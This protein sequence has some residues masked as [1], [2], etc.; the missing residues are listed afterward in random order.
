MSATA[1]YGATGAI[2]PKAAGY[3]IVKSPRMSPELM[4]MWEQ[5]RGGA[6]PGVQA[7]LGQ[8]SQLAGGGNEELWRQLEAPAM[9][10]F[11]QLQGQTASRFSQASGGGAMSS[12]RG[13]A[14]QNEMGGAAADLAERLQ[15]HR[16]GLQRGAIQ[17]LLGMYGDL[18][19]HDPYEMLHIQQERK[20]NIWQ[21]LLGGFL[22]AAGAGIGGYF[23]GPMGA[24]LGG[25]LGG[26]AGQ[27]F[28]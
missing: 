2:S 14:F 7:G 11:G 28:M 23:G 25:Q 16:L 15:G 12:R 3:D 9:R 17:Q 1:N 8:L 5:L 13:S 26:A 4:Q 18:M 22:P 6:Q 19:Q 21:K 27:A 24:S 20:P 10:Q